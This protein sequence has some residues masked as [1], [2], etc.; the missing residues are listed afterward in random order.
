MEIDSLAYRTDLAMLELSGSTVTDRGGYLVVRT[1][2]NPTFWWGNHLLLPHAPRDA[3]EANGWVT[4]FEREFPEARHR[5]F[6]VDGTTGE[7]ADLAAFAALGMET[8]VLSVM[9]ATEVHP[10]P[11]PNTE[12]AVRTLVSDDDW[13]QQVELSMVGEE[14]GYNRAFCTARTAAERSLVEQGY[15]AWWGAFDGATL[16][17]S[18]GL[19]TASP[20]LARFQHVKTHPDSRG[21]G[22]AGTLVH[23]AS[24]YGFEELGA[25]TLVMVADPDYL[26]IRIYR[27]VGFA[28][29]ERQ[30]QVTR[31]PP[32]D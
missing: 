20:G 1:P 2:D 23:R 3:E 27:S 6:G 8:E 28:D 16:L 22:L 25:R 15:G 31:Q 26:A 21:R 19:F 13:S 5:T 17:A 12:A 14:F 18:L 10:P 30:L 29:T 32:H 9:T 11:H 4:T 24:R 7:L